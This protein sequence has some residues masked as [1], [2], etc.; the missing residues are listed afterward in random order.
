M[1]QR[2]LDGNMNGCSQLQE[3]SDRDLR[4]VAALMRYDN[5]KSIALR[6]L[7][8]KDAKICNI[9]Q[10]YHKAEDRSYEILK[11]WRD[12]VGAS[13]PATRKDLLEMF[14]QARKEG[15]A[16]DQDA[17]KYLKSAS[18]DGNF[19]LPLHENYIVVIT[20]IIQYKY[21]VSGNQAQLVLAYMHDFIGPYSDSSM[22]CIVS[23]SDH[24]HTVIPP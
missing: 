13:A 1:T 21:R 6:I 23:I 9:E 18:P 14:D 5:V 22:L 12:T 19:C 11:C 2:S 8:I 4:Q 17:I 15:M 10:D 3:L 16:V 7:D 24:V 20:F